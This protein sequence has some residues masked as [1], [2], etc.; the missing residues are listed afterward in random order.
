VKKGVT[1]CAQK[2]KN[3]RNQCY[4]KPLQPTATNVESEKRIFI[5]KQ[6]VVASPQTLIQRREMV[7]ELYSIPCYFL[8]TVVFF[9]GHSFC[10]Y[11]V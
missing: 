8:A 5:P 10:I 6:T 7:W 2:K 9:A 11:P 1:I 4:R 3:P